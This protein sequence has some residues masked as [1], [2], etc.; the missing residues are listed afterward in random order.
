[1]ALSASKLLVPIVN[2]VEQLYPEC[3][4]FYLNR[5]N[6]SQLQVPDVFLGLSREM[7]VIN[8]AVTSEQEA[9]RAR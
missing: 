9:L 4:V 8:S 5:E 2:A 3:G 6:E 7:S 1:V